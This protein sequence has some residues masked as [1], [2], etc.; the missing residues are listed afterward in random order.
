MPQLSITSA[1]VWVSLCHDRSLGPTEDA[2]A[3]LVSAATSCSKQVGVKTTS[4][5]ITNT[6][7]ERDHAM[8][9]LCARENP[10]LRTWRLTRAWGR[11]SSIRVTDA[12]EELLSITIISQSLNV[13]ACK[14]S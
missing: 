5:F 1:D 9:K 2:S 10:K 14:L 7:G 4:G 11:C 8:P 6:Y 12:S 3:R 13:C